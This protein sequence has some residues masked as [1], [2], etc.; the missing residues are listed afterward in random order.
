MIEDVDGSIR[1]DVGIELAP[2]IG[3]K[4]RGGVL[5]KELALQEKVEDDIGIEQGSHHR[6]FSITWVAYASS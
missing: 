6:Y 4:E 2:M 1:R 3:F 5:N